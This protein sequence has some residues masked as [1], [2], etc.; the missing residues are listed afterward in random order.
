[1]TDKPVALVTGSS[2]G[3]GKGI[4]EHFLSQGYVVAGCSRGPAELVDQS[5]EHTEMDV[6][7][8]KQVWQ[9]VIGVAR[10]HGRL[11]LVINNAAVLPP[12]ILAMGTSNEVV[13]SAI[14]TNFLGTY[15]V[16]REAAKAM[17]RH[18]SGR[19]INISTIATGMHLEGASAYL[20][21]KAA[22]VEFSKVLAKELALNGITV[23]V[24]AISLIETDM[25]GN[26]TDEVIKRYEESFAIKR[27]ANI[28]DVCNVLSF[29]ASPASGY[30]TGQV[31]H[32]GYVD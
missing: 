13:E 9:W 4:A 5:Y 30:V 15:A 31:I 17:L 1:M 32:L 25:I 11:D 7:C 14:R 18:K 3:V 28:E 8:E 24:L 20:A 12:S 22:V 21:S 19:I 2:R 10:T 23:N 16:C 26:L 27:W 6:G 29:F